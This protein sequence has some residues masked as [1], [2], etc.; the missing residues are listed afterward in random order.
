MGIRS[1]GSED[2]ELYFPVL[3]WSK[4]YHGRWYV[5]GDYYQDGHRARPRPAWARGLPARGDQQAVPPSTSPNYRFGLASRILALRRYMLGKS[6][7]IV[8]VQVLP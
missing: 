2:F 1:F 7:S 3:R 6:L 4:A 8:N 5:G